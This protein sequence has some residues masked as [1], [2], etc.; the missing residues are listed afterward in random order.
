MFFRKILAVLGATLFFIYA[1]AQTPLNNYDKAWKKID[2]LINKKGLTQSALTEVNKLYALAKKEKQEAQQVK[3]LLYKMSLQ[4]M[5]EE[6]ALLKS[7]QQLEIE[8]S[9]AGETVKSILHSITAERY[10]NYFQQHRWQL[11]NRTK[12]TDFK[13][14]DIATWG[15]DDFHKKI[16]QLYLESLKNE[17]QLQ[18]TKLEPFD[19]III[20]GNVRHLRPTL[21]DL[22][23]HRAL[24]YFRNDEQDVNKPSYAFELDQASIFDPAA[25]F[26][27]RK[28]PTKDSLSLHHEALLL[29]QRLIAFH[30]NDKKPDAL[31]DADIN[32]L[33]FVHQYAEMDKKEELYKNA[34]T[35]IGQQYENNPVAAQAWFL[36]A[37][38]HSEKASEEITYDGYGKAKEICDKIIAQKDSSEGKINAQN[39]L[40][41]ILKQELNLQTEKV[42]LPNQPFRMLVTYRNINQTYFRLVTL[43]KQ[44][45]NK[46]R[47]VNNW[48][49]E[50]WQQL[51]Q[52]PV[53]KTFTQPLPA[54]KDYRQHRVEVSMEGLPVGEYILLASTDK[55]FGF[56]ENVVAAQFFYTSAIAYLNN[57]NNFFVVHRETGNPLAR[58][59]VQVWYR[60]YDYSTQKNIDRKGENLFTDK[61]GFF[62]IEPPRTNSN[63]NY[64]LELTNG[65]DHL[66]MEDENY[67]SFN[68]AE[69]VLEKDVVSSFLFTDR[70]IYR[71]GQIVYFKGIVINRNNKT[72]ESNIVPGRKATIILYDANGQKTDSLEVTSNEFGSYSGRF[73][74]PQNQLNGSFRIEDNSN[75]SNLSFSLEE[76]KRPKFSIEIAKPSGTYKLNDSI[77]ITGTAKAYAGNS[78]DGAL[79]K[80]R[81]VR[82][83]RWPIWF[84]YYRQGKIW[85]PR[86]SEE[87][88][89]GHGEMKTDAKGEFI[90]TF[91]AL[92]DGS[93]DKK[94]QPTFYYE[95]SADVTDINGETRSGNTSVAVAY[96][97]LQL[98]INTPGE[99][100]ANDFKNL[101]IRSENLNG[102]FEKA[103]VTVIIHK[104]K[105][106]NRIFRSRYWEQPDQFLMSEEEYHTQ[107]PYD[108][109]KDE[110]L[111]TNWPKQ[112]IIAE[113]TDTT[114]ETANYK[115]PT[116]NFPPG[117]YF[118]EV[119]TKDKNGE[120]VK[121]IKTIQLTGNQN[122]NPVMF[123]S[124]QSIKSVYEPGEKAI[125]TLQTN[126]DSIWVIHHLTR[127][128]KEAEQNLFTLAGGAKSFDI[129]ITEADRGGVALDMAFVKHNRVFTDNTTLSVPYTNK[130]L[131]ISYETFRDK[132]L[133][134]SEEKWKVKISGYKTDKVAAE[135]LTAMYDASL[136]QF[137]PQSW[138]L[139]TIWNKSAFPKL[140]NGDRGFTI[141]HSQNKDFEEPAV[142]VNKVY[143]EMLA[144]MGMQHYAEREMY[145]RNKGE[146]MR[147]QVPDLNAEPD[148]SRGITL[149]SALS[150]RVAGISVEAAKFTTPKIVK[151]EEIAGEG[152][153]KN[154]QDAAPIQIR[155]NF[156]ETAF[157]IPDLKTDSAGNIEFSFTMPEALTQWKWMSLAHTKG[158][159]FGYSEK[160]IVTQKE[161]MVQPNAPRFVREGDR[162]DFTT[163][164][165]N[166]TSKELTGQ[167]QLQL[168]DPSTN[169]SVDGWFNNFFPN[170][171][172]T[173]PAGQSVPA[174]FS[175]GIPFQYNKPVV[176]RIIASS[177][178][179]GGRDGAVSDGEE[180][181]LPVL[182]NRM[183]VTESLPLNMRGSRTKEFKF[184]KLINSGEG[185]PGASETLNHQALTIEFTSN[186]A[187]YAVQALPYLMEYP[188]ECAEQTFNRFYSNTLATHITN[189][190]PRIKQVF[191]KWLAPLSS[192]RGA[193][194]EVDSTA[195]WSNLQKNQE[196]K[197]VLLQETPWV[198]QANN[199]TQQKK[200]IALLFDMVRMSR[201][202]EVS[203]GRLSE[204]QSSNGGFVWFTGGPD[205]RYITQYILTGI[206]HLKKLN[207]LPKNNEKLNAI[208]KKAMAYLD[209]KIKEDYDRLVKNKANL[210]TQQLNTNE[211]QYLYMR[212]FFTEMNVPG[213]SFK[214][215]NYYRKQAQ[216]YW[217]KESRYMQGMIALS[218]YRTG[219]IQTAKDIL[220][221]LQQN[222]LINEEMGMYWKEFNTGGYYWYQS[223]IESHALLTEAFSEINKNSKITDDLKTWLLKQKQTHNWRTTKATADACYILLL[224]GSNWLAQEPIV[225]ISLG[226]T[227][228]STP[229]SGAG[230][231]GYFKKVI[232]GPKVKANMGNI[233]VTISQP[234]QATNQPVNSTAWGAAYWQYFEELDKITP[235]STPL[236]LVKKLFVEK[237][238]DRG[239]VL[240]PLKEGEA[241]HVGEKV[242]VRI[243]LRVDRSLE[244]VHMKDMRASSLEPVNVISQ[245]K[246]QGGLGYYESTKDASTNFFF[247][248]LPRGTWVFEYP[249][250][251][252]HT[253]TFSNGVTTIQCMY[254]PEFTSHSQGLKITV[255]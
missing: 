246:W 253:G 252:T 224:E 128:D 71:P 61:N 26:I 52:L 37:R 92:P 11:Y 18:Q 90:I 160:T 50:Y 149:D 58:T 254:A 125:Y 184:D 24:Y 131:K 6:D 42:N 57:G 39:L 191:E 244:Y 158:L 110:N 17:K 22:L 143:D 114:S 124:V 228:L 242:K 13:K 67:N 127:V 137:Q 69:R 236:K 55:E 220:K 198:L 174:S 186:P 44:L 62:K 150:G 19:A 41:T 222:A 255:E 4:E 1:T 129:P 214:A 3:T 193:G 223:P 167:V 99:L 218:L 122:T 72:A 192:R 112:E 126:L 63:N 206:G 241:L 237:N 178:A 163:K 106:P 86:R 229:G 7:I 38:W 94:D 103:T 105:Q 232:D 138:D 102:I 196:L 54:V 168:I 88:E 147:M 250:F 208:I 66:F 116:T 251:V 177:P 113:S 25:D 111:V 89:I 166:L 194:G 153:P 134:A 179:G 65:D 53:A 202:M 97:A 84:D 207:A 8:S 28:F 20:K 216:Q 226:S 205:D 75:H 59:N 159:A 245:Y 121:A 33:E 118:V 14:N 34:L 56:K 2:S 68:Y 78:I 76:Y 151:D 43:T 108:I 240:Q 230:G 217:V 119:S 16:G 219:D 195:L 45:K 142:Y 164:I 10:W 249:L 133:P 156:N 79:V 117:W 35:H 238:T 40:K 212:S 248:Y 141:T 148:G 176:Y 234:N 9:T 101:L 201:E 144:T 161:L 109:Y 100:P 15:I 173:V 200:N 146:P 227:P 175:I 115:L 83:T 235:S 243:E 225:E 27:N 197:S 139:P 180:M 171:Y 85:P 233:S 51:L 221:S 157:F 60:Y 64:R 47:K 152:L 165:V 132:T 162:M 155:R 48:Q 169:Q 187:W 82:Q 81:V 231:E 203:L 247:G 77:E 21:F 49:E 209:K 183:L 29:D 189:S 32:R 30:L 120:T 23:A 91:K 73:T 188:Y 12:T 5:K 74:L 135:M 199:E 172:F 154:K 130:Q 95:V 210:I 93:I 96:Q 181:M 204:M 211:I 107:F 215:Y 185:K 80:Y 70:S 136:D 213:E 140:F 239:P 31:I 123:G 46:L 170:Q 98:I 182:S 87:F 190:S 104:L 36:L 145:N